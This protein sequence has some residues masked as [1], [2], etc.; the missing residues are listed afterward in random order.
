MEIRIMRKMFLLLLLPFLLGAK[1]G[2][3]ESIVE[4]NVHA[5]VKAKSIS[6]TVAAD[7][8]I[9]GNKPY[10]NIKDQ[11]M[12]DLEFSDIL[13]KREAELLNKE[14]ALKEKEGFINNQSKTIGDDINSLEAKIK[15]LNSLQA[16][17][18][19]GKEAKYKK[20]A[21]IYVKMKPIKAAN[22]L[23]DLDIN[24]A[25]EIISRMKDDKVA[26]ILN[27]LP[28][29]VNVMFTQGLLEK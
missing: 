9:M 29:E 20:L 1:L 10:A 6:E 11:I 4:T 8:T 17:K 13:K 19:S 21:K 2:A 5:E 28:P 14:K 22:A 18:L 26:K 23:K 3:Q 16:S 24:D 7:K 15:K 25:L 12:R 27:L